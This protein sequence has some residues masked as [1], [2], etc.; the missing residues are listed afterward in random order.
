MVSYS[1]F[2]GTSGRRRRD[3]SLYAAG[4][5]MVTLAWRL[6]LPECA[7]LLFCH[8]GSVPRAALESIDRLAAAGHLRLIE[9]PRSAG[10]AGVTWRFEPLW[11]DVE[12]LFPRDLDSL[13][14]PAEGAN[15]RFFA[16]SGR[17]LHAF[18]PWFHWKLCPAGLCGLRASAI[19]T[20]FPEP[21]SFWG[22]GDYRRYGAEERRLG[23]L[24]RRLRDRS[25]E[26][27]A[28]VRFATSLVP[29]RAELAP[30]WPVVEGYPRVSYPGQRLRAERI[31]RLT[32]RLRGLASAK[33]PR[34]A[35]AP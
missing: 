4:V 19:R 1:L 10:L 31:G 17:A 27:P 26:A 2:G 25:V 6:L 34:M 30:L 28:S 29:T 9:R 22:E 12:C 32:A 23:V 3:V 18:R 20:L 33:S 15:M 14:T 21:G 11:M 13:P 16:A 35:T 5:E 7:V 8:R 24:A